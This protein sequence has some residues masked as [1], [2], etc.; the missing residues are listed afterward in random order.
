MTSATFSAWPSAR[1]LLSEAFA[2]GFE[3]IATIGVSKEDR[4]AA[5]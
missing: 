2:M 3:F 1:D 5:L 4:G